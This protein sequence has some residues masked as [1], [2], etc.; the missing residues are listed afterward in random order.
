MS[1][2]ARSREACFCNLLFGG[3]FRKWGGPMR[4]DDLPEGR[5]CLNWLQLIGIANEDELCPDFIHLGGNA[6]QLPGA[7]HACFINNKDV[8]LGDRFVAIFPGTIP[9]KPAFRLLM[10]DALCNSSAAFRRRLRHVP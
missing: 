2:S 7:Q 8:T 9:T 3:G 4:F 10:P 1:P 6:R 5:A